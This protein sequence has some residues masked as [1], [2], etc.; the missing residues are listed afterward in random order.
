VAQLHPRPDHGERLD[1]VTPIAGSMA[2]SIIPL[3][4]HPWWCATCRRPEVDEQSPAADCVCTVV[5][6]HARVATP[7]S[8]GALL[9]D[10]LDCSVE[11]IE[12][13]QRLSVEAQLRTERALDQVEGSLYGVLS[14]TAEV[15]HHLGNELLAA[16]SALTCARLAAPEGR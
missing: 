16:H 6:G 1:M 13:A 12:N 11:R 2:A 14:V 8:A 5:E 15:L 3:T 10:R 7:G 4:A 9:A